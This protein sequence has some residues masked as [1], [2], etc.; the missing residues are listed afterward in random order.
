MPFNN[1]INRSLLFLPVS[2]NVFVLSDKMAK[3]SELREKL[4]NGKVSELPER[5]FSKAKKLNIN[6]NENFQ[7][8][9]KPLVIRNAKQVKIGK[10]LRDLFTKK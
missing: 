7:I 10:Q 3:D 4:F 8:N 6:K 1:K 5:Y 9:R 2:P